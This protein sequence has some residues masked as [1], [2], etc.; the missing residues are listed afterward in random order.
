MAASD[1]LVQ[2]GKVSELKL[3]KVSRKGD[4]EKGRNC[5]KNARR[6]SRKRSLMF[7]ADH[8][9]GRYWGLAKDSLVREDGPPMPV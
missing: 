3:A 5:L 9:Q 8:G 6:A 7:T 1:A 4:M 2:D